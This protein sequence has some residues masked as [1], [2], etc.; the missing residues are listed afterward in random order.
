M[1][2]KYV[3]PNENIELHLIPDGAEIYNNGVNSGV[4]NKEMA[5][6]FISIDGTKRLH[7]IIKG[8]YFIK[9][10][11]DLNNL[12]EFIKKAKS[13]GYITLSENPTKVHTRITGDREHYIPTHIMVEL[14]YKCNLLCK[15]CYTKYYKTCAEIGPRKWI[16]KLKIMKELG[17]RYVEFTGG[18][19]LIKNDFNKILLFSLEKFHKVGI[20]TNG[21]NFKPEIFRIISENKEKV[22]VNISLDSSD[23]E[24]HDIIRG[25]GGAF[26]N[27]ISTIRML[28][29][30]EIFVRVTMSVNE[31]NLERVESTLLLA[32]EA[33]AKS[34]VLGPVL[35]LGKGERFDIISIPTSRRFVKVTEELIQKY[36]DFVGVLDD[37]KLKAAEYFGNCGLGWRS[38]TI[39]PDGKVRACPFLE[40]VKNFI[41]GDIKKWLPNKVFKNKAL[42]LY[43]KLKAPG[44][45]ICD[46]CKDLLFC[47]GCIVR[48]L[49]M[50]RK[51]GSKCRW[52]KTNEEVLR[53]LLK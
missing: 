4:I 20:L 53:C 32:K 14:T 37:E 16:E 15:H 5:D 22:L 13:F 50:A 35:P 3:V 36:R 31:Q 44:P 28:S 7:E 33:G 45:E 23:P 18:E 46:D 10:Q 9:D 27:A 2:N 51:K 39:A 40:P 12:L 42:F 17:V 41:I 48:G 43:R 47:K 1:L 21:Y 19:P 52:Y 11:E 26:Q 29:E 8:L 30:K 38:V 25:K 6:F 49:K 34:F 24:E